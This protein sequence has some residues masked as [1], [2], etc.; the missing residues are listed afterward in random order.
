MPLRSCARNFWIVGGAAF[1]E[2]PYVLAVPAPMREE[3]SEERSWDVMLVTTS[4]LEKLVLSQTVRASRHR[5][6]ADNHSIRFGRRR[7][8]AVIR[9][10]S[11]A[12]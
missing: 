2:N 11:F 10:G 8:A 5:H 4:Q 3:A 6:E 9:F 1:R 7:K 12:R